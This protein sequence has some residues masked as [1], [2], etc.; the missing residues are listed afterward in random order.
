LK[1]FIIA[2]LALLYVTVSSGA[3]IHMHY[4]MDKLVDWS[5]GHSNDERCSECGMEK[6]HA[7]SSCCKDEH[8]QVK[9]KDDQKIS[10]AP[11]YL[12]QET[13]TVLSEFPFGGYSLVPLPSLSQE[14]PVSHA[15]PAGANQVIYLRNCNFRI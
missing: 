1:K 4:C 6:N 8:K 2:I 15:P 3:T 11:I 12:M 7:Q 10:E 14:H 13:S 9:L 5:L